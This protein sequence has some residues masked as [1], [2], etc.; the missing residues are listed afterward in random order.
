MPVGIVY[1]PRGNER[2][3]FTAVQR[4]GRSYVHGRR[5]AESVEY[6][7]PWTMI[8]HTVNRHTSDEMIYRPIIVR[9]TTRM[10]VITHCY[11][12]QQ[13]RNVIT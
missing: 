4:P 2:V 7:Q 3:R 10:Q 1:F 8:Q 11:A 5:R 12:I 6:I 13:P 9:T